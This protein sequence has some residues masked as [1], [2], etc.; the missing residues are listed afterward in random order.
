MMVI[1]RQLRA[2]HPLRA[3]GFTRIVCDELVMDN[4]VQLFDD[5]DLL[6]RIQYRAT[7]IKLY[8]R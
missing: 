2:E 6:Q 8:L 5:A 3:S 7:L 1:E 4:A